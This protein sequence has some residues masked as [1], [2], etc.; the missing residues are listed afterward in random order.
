[1]TT[2]K[3]NAHP[4]KRF[5]VSM[6]TRDIEL[7]D[8]ILD[9]LDNCVDGIE[10]QLHGTDNNEKPYK[11]FW[12]KITATKDKFEIWDNCGGIPTEIAINNAFRMGRDDPDRDSGIH[13]VGMYGIGMKRA[14]FKMG[15]QSCVTSKPKGENKEFFVEISSDWLEMDNWEL[16]LHYPETE[17][18]TEHGTRITIEQLHDNIAFQFDEDSSSF[19][20]DLS[21]DISQF[22]ALIIDKGFK[23][24]LNGPAIEG[25]PLTLLTAITDV[26]API[27]PYLFKANIE[28]VEVRLAVG[29]RRKLASEKELDEEARQPRTSDEAGWTVI[30]NDRVVLYCDKSQVTGWGRATVP[31]YHTQFISISGVLEFRSNK[32]LNLP[33]NTT[34]RG[35]DTSSSVYLTVFDYMTEGLKI[36]TDFTNKWKGREEETNDAFANTTSKKPREILELMD[37][38]EF[39]SVRKIDSALRYAPKLPQPEDKNPLRRIVF[40]RRADDITTLAIELFEDPKTKPSE[41]GQRCFDLALQRLKEE[42]VDK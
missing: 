39:S 30:C 2:E 24:T 40:T 23:V 21:K 9:L 42:E 17:V 10:R 18:L 37:N 27:K 20:D 4:T 3:V 28:D 33:L 36:F 7:K 19:L 6:L 1:M 38:S 35:L 5:F 26:A 8:A 25:A 29:F 14:L 31:R 15:K 41:V 11:G 16:E 34:K 32:L 22:Y 13:T 12:A